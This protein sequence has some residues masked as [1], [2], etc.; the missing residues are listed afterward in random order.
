MA[1]LED[2]IAY[3]QGDETRGR[4]AHVG[5]PPLDARAIHA[6]TD[7]TREAFAIADG[8]RLKLGADLVVRGDE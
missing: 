5:D 2:A 4:V 6:A 8:L 7:K 1:G 3:M